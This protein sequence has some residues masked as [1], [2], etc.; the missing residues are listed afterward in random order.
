MIVPFATTEIYQKEINF[1]DVALV[2][3]QRD[4]YMI[5]CSSS[6]KGLPN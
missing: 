1:S 6:A 5:I 2:L 3:L 4:R